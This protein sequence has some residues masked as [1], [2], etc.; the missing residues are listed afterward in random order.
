M[1]PPADR[2][3]DFE[4]RM[5]SQPRHLAPV[6]GLVNEFCRQIGFEESECGKVCLAVSEAIAN[7]INHGYDRQDDGAITM[8]LWSLQSPPGVV[9][10]LEDEAR[11]VDPDKICSRDLD[12]VRPG[13][14]G[15]HIMKEVMDSVIYERRSEA[16]GMCLTMSKRAAPDEAPAA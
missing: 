9:V 12:D 6:R 2:G 14:L 3:P 5:F 11:P 10:V 15:V 7:I 8:K 1:T 13:G 16:A 4:V